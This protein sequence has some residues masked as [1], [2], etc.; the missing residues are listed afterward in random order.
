MKYEKIHGYLTDAFPRAGSTEEL[1][2]YELTPEQ[3]AS[4]RDNGFLTGVNTLSFDQVTE[5]ARRLELVRS[6]LH[7]HMDSL[8]EVEADYLERPNEV[9]F[10]FLGA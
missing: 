4:Y 1:K 5:L 2:R 7:E 6:G 9:V 3:V 10:H 8:Y